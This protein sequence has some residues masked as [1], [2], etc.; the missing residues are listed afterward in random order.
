MLP[1]SDVKIKSSQ[2]R[3]LFDDLIGKE[4][5]KSDLKVDI[6]QKTIEILQAI[7]SFNM[8]LNDID[9]QMKALSIDPSMYQNIIKGFDKVIY[10]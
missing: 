3:N 7:E 1:V 5:L 4:D 6:H 9:E 8:Q 2:E 10:Q